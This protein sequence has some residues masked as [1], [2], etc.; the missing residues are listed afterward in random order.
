MANPIPNRL[1]IISLKFVG[2]ISP[3]GS[4][5][6][7]PNAQYRAMKYCYI[8]DFYPMTPKFPSDLSQDGS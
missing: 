6:R 2:V 7:V 1:T 3:F 5:E 8:Y 4:V